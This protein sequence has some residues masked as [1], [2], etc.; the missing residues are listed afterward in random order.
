MMSPPDVVLHYY[1]SC[2]YVRCQITPILALF[3]FPATSLS[4]EHFEDVEIDS[5][6]VVLSR[7]MR[8]EGQERDD[9]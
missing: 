6:T 2:G 1:V 9:A 3:H 5:S 4:E 8:F 7:G